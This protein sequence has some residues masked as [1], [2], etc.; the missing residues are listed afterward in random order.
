LAGAPI[1]KARSSP[2]VARAFEGSAVFE[3]YQRR[4]WLNS[5]DTFEKDEDAKWFGLVEDTSFDLPVCRIVETPRFSE[6]MESSVHASPQ[7][8]KRQY[9]SFV[10]FV[11]E[12]GA[13][14]SSLSI[15]ELNLNG[16]V[17]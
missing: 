8:P 14:K 7:S 6:I 15:C 13:G 3:I 10:S 1:Q 2:E 9:P 5:S 4:V 12:T 11:G 17:D 16:A